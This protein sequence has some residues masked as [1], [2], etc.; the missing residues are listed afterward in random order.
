[1]DCLP[2]AGQLMLRL[3]SATR[4][5]GRILPIVNVPNA[6]FLNRA[7]AQ[8]NGDRHVTCPRRIYCKERRGCTELLR[9]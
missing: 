7:V 3:V 6:L 8:D 5:V 9:F 4:L 1:M 2:V